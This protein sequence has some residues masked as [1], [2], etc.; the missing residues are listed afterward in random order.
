M[1]AQA[2]LDSVPAARVMRL[3]AVLRRASGQLGLPR[4]HSVTLDACQSVAVILLFPVSDVMNWT[5]C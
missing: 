3:P 2:A 4:S 5:W 1:L